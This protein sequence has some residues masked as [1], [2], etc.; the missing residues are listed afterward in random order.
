MAN[1]IGKMDR[2][3]RAKQFMPFD[4]LK[5]FREALAEK[6]RIIVPRRELSEEQKE[7]L[8]RKFWQIRRGDIIT[9]E[10]FQSGEY[11]KVTGMVSRIDE[12]S[13][14]LKVVNTSIAF[15]DISDLKGKCIKE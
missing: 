8:N 4:A 2:A 12:T 1:K 15:D 3:D 11:I 14:L 6:E 5:G 13:R 10:F 9:V 7:E